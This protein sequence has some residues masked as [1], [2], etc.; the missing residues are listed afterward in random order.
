METGSIAAASDEKRAAAPRR[1]EQQRRCPVSDIVDLDQ[2]NR[3]ASVA[4]EEEAKMEAQMSRHVF[5][6]R[7]LAAAV[8]ISLLAGCAQT[9]SQPVASNPP[10]VAPG[11]NAVWYTVSF[12]TGSYAIN[13][14]GRKVISEVVAAMKANP[15]AVATVIGRTDTVGSNDYNMRLS[16]R[17]A[18]AVRDAL[19]Y[20]GS[21]TMDRV[22]ARW[23]GE[24][25]QGVPT[26]DNVAATQNRV[27]DIAIH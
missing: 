14:D 13:A 9:S 24:A 22:E 18:D 7:H 17:R 6:W 16:H 2:C 12:D 10:P 8:V 20:D 4:K 19:V 11:A 23:T 1:S 3:W 26:G 15:A 5:A 27:V 25:R 21:V